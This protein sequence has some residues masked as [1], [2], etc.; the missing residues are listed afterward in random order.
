[1]SIKLQIFEAMSLFHFYYLHYN[2]FLFFI[3]FLSIYTTMLV[4]LYPDFWQ[5]CL[6]IN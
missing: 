3:F 4:S 1:M 2:I 6:Q 5:A